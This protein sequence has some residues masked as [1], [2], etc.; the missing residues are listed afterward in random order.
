MT[1]TNIDLTNHLGFQLSL[2]K[3]A[4]IPGSNSSVNPQLSQE[5]SMIEALVNQLPASRNA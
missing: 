1:T 5:A 3:L 2:L 4:N